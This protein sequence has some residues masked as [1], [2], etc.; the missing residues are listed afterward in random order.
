MYSLITLEVKC[1]KSVSLGRNQESVGLC[2]FWMLQELFGLSALSGCWHSLA[3]AFN[4][5]LCGHIYFPLLY[6][7]QISLCFLLNNVFMIAFWA[8]PYNTQIKLS[9]SRSLNLKQS[10]GFFL[11]FLS[12]FFFFLMLFIQ[13]NIHRFQGSGCLYLAGYSSIQPTAFSYQGLIGS[14][15][16]YTI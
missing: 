12:F 11:F 4:L 2:S 1:L 13:S 9:I 6:V 7:C 8:H 16:P 14:I 5:C 10:T 15:R 3:S